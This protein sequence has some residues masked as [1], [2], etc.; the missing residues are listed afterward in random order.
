MQKATRK[1]TKKATKSQSNSRV[2][3]ARIRLGTR[4]PRLTGYLVLNP[5]IREDLL[6]LPPEL[7]HYQGPKLVHEEW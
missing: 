6:C 3:G 5:N 7:F 1:A 4:V 2:T